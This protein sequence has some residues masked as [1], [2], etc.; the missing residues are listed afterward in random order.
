MQLIERGAYLATLGEHLGSAVAGRGRLVLVS[1]EAGVG[2]TSLVRAFVE[3]QAGK[4]RV[5]WAACDGLFTPEPLAPLDELAP[6]IDRIGGRREVFAAALEELGSGPTIAVVEDAHWADEATLDLLRYLGRRLDGTTVLLI[7]TYRDDEIGPQHPLRLVLGDV[8][9]ARRIALPRLTEHGVHTLAEGSDVDPHELYRQTGGN[10]FFVTEVLAAG[11]TGVPASVRD[12]V[13]ARAA[14][15]DGSARAVLTRRSWQA[16]RP[17]WRCS[18]RFAAAAARARRMPRRRRPPESTRWRGLQARAGARAIEEAIAGPTGGAALTRLIARART[19]TRRGSPIT[20]RR[21]ATP[22]PFSSMPARPPS[23]PPTEARTARRPSSTHGAFAS[24]TVSRRTRLPSSSSIARASARSR[25]RSTRLSAGLAALTLPGSGDRLKEGELLSW[26]SR[27]LYWAARLEEA[28]EAAHEA[29]Q[30][31]E[32]LPPGR[33]LAL[34]YVQMAAQRVVSLDAQGV[35]VWGRRAIEL[36]EKLGEDEIVVG[37]TI[38]IGTA[39]S[40]LGDACTL[41]K[42]LALA[43]A[44]GT[45]EQIARVILRRFDFVRNK[46]WPA[47]DR[48]LEEGLAYSAGRDLD[49]HWVYLLAWRADAALERG[50]WDEA[51]ADARTALNHPHAVLHRAVGAARARAPKGLARISG[52]CAGAPRRDGRVRPAQPAAETGAAPARAR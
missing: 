35:V 42:A 40:M 23:G 41:D 9:M 52:R 32:E 26:S 22:R 43:Q 20:P 8:D 47:A 39:E 36:A 15:L 48:W 2:K 3:E 12:A 18:R 51:A 28:A 45:D 17:I 19:V 4:A 29:I 13:L 31:L 27:L 7:A 6:G 24:R 37:A 30:V 10:P 11:G 5:V 21:P 33:E 16:W 49:D 14:R 34:A 50:R 44:H 1:G 46:N 38:A 25:F